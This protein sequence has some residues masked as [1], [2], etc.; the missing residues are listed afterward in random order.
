MTTNETVEATNVM[1]NISF[2][3]N[4][5]V[6]G[7]AHANGTSCNRRDPSQWQ[8][9]MTEEGWVIG[10]KGKRREAILRVNKIN[11]TRESN[12]IEERSM[13]TNLKGESQVK[14]SKCNS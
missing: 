5:D 1:G 12:V 10:N 9:N 7:K 11:V 6:K 8:Q 4:I 2:N 3:G 13:S 14:D